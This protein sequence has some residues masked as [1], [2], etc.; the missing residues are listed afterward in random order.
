[1]Q[2]AQAPVLQPAVA[3]HADA[4]P[5]LAATN[6]ALCQQPAATVAIAPATQTITTTSPVAGCDDKATTPATA[7]MAAAAS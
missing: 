5:A 6:L 2:V 3:P 4:T 1:V 7:S